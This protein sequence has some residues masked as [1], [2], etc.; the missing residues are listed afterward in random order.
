MGEPDEPDHAK[1]GALKWTD[2]GKDSTRES[3][4]L[5]CLGDVR[6]GTNKDGEWEGAWANASNAQH[7]IA[8]LE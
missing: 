1:Q 8:L 5:H 2:H 7:R 6:S 3:L 4:L